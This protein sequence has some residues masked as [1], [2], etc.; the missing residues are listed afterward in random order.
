MHY[1]SSCFKPFCTSYLH[2]LQVLVL[3]CV[4]LTCKMSSVGSDQEVTRR[5]IQAVLDLDKEA[6]SSEHSLST[7]VQAITTESGKTNFDSFC[8]EI[9]TSIR[10]CFRKEGARSSARE[11]AHR[12]FHKLRMQTLP[13]IWKSFTARLG[14][15][16][17]K[18][19]QLQSVNRQLFNYLTMEF[20]TSLQP[21]AVGA[22]PRHVS[23]QAEEEN[24]IRYASGF[25]SWR[26]SFTAS[27]GFFPLVQVP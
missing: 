8:V 4:D 11:R 12:Q 7:V 24:A 18:P 15:P 27:N 13:G 16:D 25:F 23:L 14:Q 1:E 21:A 5:A 20:F 2:N 22:T 10:S 3:L 9:T 6:G 26:E 17:V 19:L